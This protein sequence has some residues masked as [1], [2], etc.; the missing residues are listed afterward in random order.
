ME[1]GVGRE[2]GWLADRGNT[3]VAVL[4]LVVS[5]EQSGRAL[6]GRVGRGGFEVHTCSR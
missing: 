3:C 2:E 4:K 5:S 1:R 6:G